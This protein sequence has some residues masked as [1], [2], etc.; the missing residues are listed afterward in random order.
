MV[1]G[2]STIRREVTMMGSGGT[3]IWMDL[4]LSTTPVEPSLTRESGK[5]TNSMAG[6]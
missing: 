4:V 1:R 5:Q 6:E 3:T 2:G